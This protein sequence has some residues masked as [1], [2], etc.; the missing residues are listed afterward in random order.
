MALPSSSYIAFQGL[1]TI[2]RDKVTGLALSGGSV[3]F[4]SDVARSV[5][6]NVFQQVQLPD[7]SY[8]FVNIGSVIPLNAA[9]AFSSPNDGTDIQ[10]YAYPY[11]ASGEFELYYLEIYSA[12]PATL[13]FT[14]EAQPANAVNDSNVETFDNSDNQIE[15]PQFVITL[16]P[17]SLTYT[18]TVSGV[19]TVTPI[20]PDWSI[21]TNG[22][23]MVT[24]TQQPLT[25]ISMPTGA[26]F[27]INISSTGITSLKLRQTITQSP[28]IL[29]QG[30]IYGTLVAK[31]F[32]ASAIQLS[33]D[34]VASNAYT[35]NL[36]NQS[37]TADG[38]YTTL[39]NGAPVAVSTTNADSPNA[40]GYVNI[41]ITIPVLTSVGITSVMVVS[42]QD[43]NSTSEF[44]QESTPRQIDHLFHYYK[45]QLAYK[46]IPSHLVGWDFPLNPAQFCTGAN[47]AV[48]ATAIG[49]N[50]SKYVWDQTLIFQSAD[51]GIDVT[52]GTANELLLTAAATT[53]MA[54]IQYLDATQARKILNAPICVNVSARAS[55]ATLATA[56]LYY[57]TDV[58]LPNP[59]TG[60]NNSIV[61]TLDANGKPATFNGNWTEVPRTLGNAQFTIGTSSTTNF[62][63]YP[64]QGWDMAG[65]AAC[66]T[67]TFF[68][69]VN[70]TASVASTEKIGFN[71]VS[72][73][74][75]N[76]PTRPAPQTP[77][78]VLRESQY[79]YE[80]TFL[81]GAVIATAVTAGQ[82]T[83]PMQGGFGTANSA[84]V[85]ANTFSVNWNVPKRI[86]PILNFYSGASSTQNN[87]NAYGI[88]TSGTS[89]S[90][91]GIGTFWGAAIINTKTAYL[92]SLGQTPGAIVSGVVNTGNAENVSGW[93]NYHYISDARLG[94]V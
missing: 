3:K 20:A 48:A 28:R 92:Q 46:P 69:I 31:S 87:I 8:N 59:T 37:T 77:D 70:G 89:N 72:L 14:R 90:E 91:R 56:S 67:A 50:K 40:P 86:A 17:N 66:N 47:R 57:T 19:G 49:A 78:E 94:I 23:G 43:A 75:G 10:V 61:L 29:G 65:I 88:G 55:V 32:T 68:A 13:Q 12:A 21:V 58:S 16:L 24:V 9:G 1:E 60:T 25:D 45:P 2:F 38:N 93:I 11:D 82:I 84:H 18:Y 44:I 6:K 74:S 83:A 41:D 15:N 76:I 52:S 85:F 36:V 79:Y 39:T 35:V 62:N 42:T 7:K 64:L 51:S 4:F 22:S 33:M 26:P 53:Q 63:D 73:Q 27:A 71:S 5:P 81:S 54:I 80:T 34:Y 30:F